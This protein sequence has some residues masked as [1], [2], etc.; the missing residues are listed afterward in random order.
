MTPKHMADLWPSL[1]TMAGMS[2]CS[3]RLPGPMQLGW[4]GSVTK[5]A[6]RFCSAMPV[7][8]VTM[9]EPKA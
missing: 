8:G 7:S 1:R 5:Q 9:A 4:P 3:G 6:P 2:V